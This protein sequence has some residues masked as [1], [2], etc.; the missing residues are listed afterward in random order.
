MLSI[1]QIAEEISRRRDAQSPLVERMIEVRDRYN[2]DVIVPAP[3]VDDDIPLSSLAPLLIADAVD[4]QADMAAQAEPTIT[5]PALDAA[6]SRSTD[7]ASRRRKALGSVWDESW[8][9]LVRHRMYRHLA[10]YA[11]SALLVELD[12]TTRMPRIPTTTWSPARTSDRALDR[13]RRGGAGASASHGRPDRA[14][15][16]VSASACGARSRPAV[17]SCRTRHRRG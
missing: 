15:T 8:M 1:E 12:H 9:D 4:N 13:P 14:D 3:S 5:V 10:G 6:S 7:Y 17:S 16:R 11:T 2:G